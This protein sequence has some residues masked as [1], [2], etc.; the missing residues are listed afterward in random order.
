MTH[1][2]PEPAQTMIHTVYLALG[3]NLGDRHKHLCD[4]LQGLR[5]VLSI[6]CVSSIYETEPV[7]YLEQPAFFNLVCKGTT[8]LSPLELLKVA[9]DTEVRLGRQ[10]TF[11][12]G[13]RVID[14]DIL[15]YD[16]LCMQKEQLTIPHP[17]MTERAFVLVPLAEIA[18]DTIEPEQ[19]RTAQ[20]LLSAI[21][22]QGVRKVGS[23]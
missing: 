14:I 23:L 1:S 6:E 13:P 16:N 18:P 9:K 2:T 22:R 21:S 7:G 3:S 12:N 20:A 10:A 19:K 17:R 8:P 4:A 5:E 11:R 15:L